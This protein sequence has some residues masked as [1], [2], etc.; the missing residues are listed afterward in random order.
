MR[1]G[2]SLTMA[3][4]SLLFLSACTQP[5]CRSILQRDT[6]GEAFR[7]AKA[8]QILNPKA[9]T[10]PEP[11]EGADGRTVELSLDK[12]RDSFKNQE[13]AS[14]QAPFPMMNGVRGF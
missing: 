8:D 10:A 4:L 7:S 9:G 5:G 11:V 1:A 6:F 13:A 12:Y 3:I 14:G 2:I